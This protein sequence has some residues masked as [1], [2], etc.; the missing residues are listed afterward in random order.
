MESLRNTAQSIDS[1]LTECVESL[2][3]LVKSLQEEAATLELAK[4]TLGTRAE[5]DILDEYG[6]ELA[7]SLEC[8]DSLKE[9]MIKTR[10]AIKPLVL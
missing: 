5:A 8:C 1:V 6:G 4:V 9:L 10:E 2:D 3:R 7:K